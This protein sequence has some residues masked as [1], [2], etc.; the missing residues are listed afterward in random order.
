MSATGGQAIKIGDTDL[1]SLPI[2][3]QLEK[4]IKLNPFSSLRT[5]ILYLSRVAQILIWNDQILEFGFLEQIFLK[6]WDDYY[7]NNLDF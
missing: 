3:Q 5:E 2:Q 1:A 7:L 4:C 6:N